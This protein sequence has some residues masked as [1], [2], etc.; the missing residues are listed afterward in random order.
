MNAKKALVTVLKYVLASRGLAVVR[1]PDH[2]RRAT[3]AQTIE[4]MAQRNHLIE[5][6]VD[7]GAS[8]GVW[9]EMLMQHFPDSSYLLVEAHPAHR[10]ALVDFC[11]RHA[12]AVSVIA[13]AGNRCGEVY[14]DDRTI[15]GGQASLVRSEEHRIALP[16]TTIDAEVNSRGLKGPYLIKLDTHGFE[17]PIFEGAANTLRRTQLIVVECYNYEVAPNSLLFYEMCA[18]LRE[19][20]FRCIDLASPVYRPYDNTFWQMDLV[21]AR[22]DRPEFSYKSYK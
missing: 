4:A 1:T 7:V 17:V 2:P 22:D 16:M 14:F 12:N 21:F 20:G 6:V 9:S 18:Y 15:F 5:C 8:N 19:R 3:M 11:R 13:A 10:E